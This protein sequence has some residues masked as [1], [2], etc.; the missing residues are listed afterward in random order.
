MVRNLVV[1]L[2]V[3]AAVLHGWSASAESIAEAEELL[4][5]GQYFKALSITRK[6]HKA[7]PDDVSAVGLLG[8]IYFELG[9][10]EKARPL[11]DKAEK[12]DEEVW[13]DLCRS[14]R[15]RIEFFYGRDARAQVILK[16][17]EKDWVTRELPV[18]MKPT[19]LSCKKSKKGHYFVYLDEPLENKRGQVFANRLM[20]T[21][22]SAYSKVFPFKKN[23]KVIYRVYI[24]S[25]TQRFNAF[26]KQLGGPGEGPSAGYFLPSTRALVINADARGSETNK[27]GFSADAIDTILHEGFHQ[28]IHMF[29]PHLPMWFDEGLAEYFGPSRFIGKG[30]LKIGVVLKHDKG[31]FETRFEVIKGAI[32]E[33]IPL[34]PWSLKKFM[35][36]DNK[37]F[38][39]GDRSQVNYAQA[40]S[41]IHFLFHSKS[42]GKKGKKLIKQYFKILRTGKSPAEA[43]K[44]T[45][46]K[47]NLEKLE[48]AWKQYVLNL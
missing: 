29:I 26:S 30:K 7:R 12:L 9:Q 3:S 37:D 34:A 31:G 20:E 42:F 23:S 38:T 48:M 15:A 27:Y 39:S 35:S 25:A 4:K 17:L 36:E 11:I 22:H 16:T 13:G 10:F 5:K 6:L 1:I 32:E 45:F 14:M 28:F 21:M 46:A 8:E 47:L 33:G 18:L 24:F 44:E 19:G 2:L 43:H 41:L 40:W